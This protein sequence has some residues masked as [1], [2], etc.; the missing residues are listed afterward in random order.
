MDVEYVITVFNQSL[1]MFYISFMEQ[2]ALPSLAQCERGIDLFWPC[3]ELFSLHS[4][5]PRVILVL[6]GCLLVFFTVG[7]FVRAF[8]ALRAMFHCPVSS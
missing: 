1:Y 5:C 3:M 4:P 2:K 6:Y 7:L 8:H